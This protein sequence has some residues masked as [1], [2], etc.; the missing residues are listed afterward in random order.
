[1]QNDEIL[2]EFRKLAQRM[3]REAESLR[4]I[5]GDS[6]IL[7]TYA[8]C[9]NMDAM[10]LE[11]VIERIERR[12]VGLWTTKTTSS[13]SFPAAKQSGDVLGGVRPEDLGE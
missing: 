1:M 6:D 2:Q 13:G 4:E 5:A 8:F 10:A 12:P 3:H 11:E 7:H 9:T